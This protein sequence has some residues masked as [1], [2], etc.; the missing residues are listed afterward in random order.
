MAARGIGLAVKMTFYAPSKD[1]FGNNY[2]NKSNNLT[3][4][5]TMTH[6]DASGKQAF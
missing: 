5:H 4:S 3:H 1:S 6:F 2:G